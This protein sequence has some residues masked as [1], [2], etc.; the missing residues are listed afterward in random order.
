MASGA[1]S[2]PLGRFVPKAPVEV[3]TSQSLLKPAYVGRSSRFSDTPNPPPPPPADRKSVSSRDYTREEDRSGDY[4]RKDR[5]GSNRSHG[6]WVQGTQLGGNLLQRN[7][8]Q[9]I[10]KKLF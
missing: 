2:T 9:S 8:L 3:V 4:H 5:G 1:N 6:S 10:E 7:F